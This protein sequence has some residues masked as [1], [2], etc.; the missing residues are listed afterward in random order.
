MIRRLGAHAGAGAR[1]RRGGLQDPGNAGAIIRSAAAAGATGV[2]LDELVRGS[3]G[4]EGAARRRWEACSKSP[5]CAAARWRSLIDEWRRRRRPD[6]S[7]PCRAAAR[8]CTK[9]TSRGRPLSCLAAK[10]RACPRHVPE[11]ADQR[12]SIPMHG[13]IESLNAAVA[14]GGPPL[15]GAAAA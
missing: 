8:R 6:L 11:A 9:S 3:V 5:S 13:A 4:M 1:A 12:V 14:G 10:A 15:R 7:R 2:V